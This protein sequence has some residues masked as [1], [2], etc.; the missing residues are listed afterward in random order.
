MAPLVIIVATVGYIYL[1]AITNITTP[2]PLEQSHVMMP[3]F[4]R[5]RKMYSIGPTA[6]MPQTLATVAEAEMVRAKARRSSS[7]HLKGSVQKSVAKAKTVG[8]AAAAV[9][10][11]ALKA[12]GRM[13]L[14]SAVV[15][16]RGTAASST[17]SL[18][19]SCASRSG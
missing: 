8:A 7:V 17:S 14:L 10:V 18:A 12:I 4:L 1:P 5:R 13:R 11:A 3:A 16:V 19:A 6:R 9:P 15:L 2:E